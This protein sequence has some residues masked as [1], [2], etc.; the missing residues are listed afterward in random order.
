MLKNTEGRVH[1]K[2][3]DDFE[4]KEAYQSTT[5]QEERK[6]REDVLSSDVNSE[7]LDTERNSTQGKHTIAPNN[8]RIMLKSPSGLH[9]KKASNFPPSLRAANVEESKKQH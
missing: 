1:N 4:V 7:N 5:K 6:R 8:D 9:H 3:L 2:S